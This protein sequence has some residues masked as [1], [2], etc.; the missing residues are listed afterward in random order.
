M[1]NLVSAVLRGRYSVDT[2]RS[3]EE[4]LTLIRPDSEYAVI[5][6]DVFMS[7][8]SGIE[9]LAHCAKTIPDAVRIALTGDARRNT[10]VDSVNYAHVFRFVSKPIRMEVLSD[11]IDTAVQRYDSQRVERDMMETTV[12]TSVNLLLEVLAT[13]D[14]PSFELS[15]RLRGSV[16]FFARAL[17]LQNVWE[18]ELAASLARI[19]TVALPAEVLRKVAR[20]VPLSPRE[21]EL[22]AEV[23]HLGSQL[24][25]QIP[26][27]DR[28]AQAIRYQAKNFDGSGLPADEVSGQGIPMGG[29][30]LR[31]FK[32]RAVLENNRVTPERVQQTMAAKHGVYDPVLLEAC[33]RHFPD[34]IFLST[35][36]DKDPRF[37]SADQLQPDMTLVTEIRTTDRLLLVAAGTRL[38]PLMVQRIRSHATLGSVLGPFAIQ[39]TPGDGPGSSDTCPPIPIGNSSADVPA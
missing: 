34:S 2:A 8:M 25:K 6:A 38:T 11:L 17:R 9:L 16:R 10:V 28:I 5:V 18:L 20:E 22:V 39:S 30:I 21:A 26:R 31:I 32:D 7:G 35:L 1:L 36:L 23:P 24:L 3:A 12:R 4:A 13:L 37:L 33:F 14:P 15:Q 27:M 29:R 19:G